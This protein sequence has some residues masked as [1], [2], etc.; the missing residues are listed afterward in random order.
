MNNLHLTNFDVH[1]DFRG[2]LT[3]ILNVSS[4]AVNVIN[5][6]VMHD[7][8]ELLRDVEH[9]ATVTAL[10]F[11]S[12]KESGFLAGADLRVIET[13]QTPEAALEICEAGQGLLQRLESLRVPTVA[14]IN[15]VC[16]GGGLEFAL[17]CRH[18]LVIDDPRTKLGLP[19]VEL[20]LLPGWGGTQRLPRLIGLSA[21]LPMLL[22]GKKVG[23]KEA[24]RIGLADVACK[25]DEADDQVAKLLGMHTSG[26]PVENYAADSSFRIGSALP[27]VFDRSSR[28][29][30]RDGVWKWLKDRTSAGQWLVKKIAHRQIASNS[31]HYPALEAIL[32]AVSVGLSEGVDRGYVVERT[33]FSKLLM[34]ETHRSLLG[35]FFQRERARKAETWVRGLTSK[36]RRI[37]KIGVIGGGV[38]GA[39][40][41]HWASLQGFEI[42]LKEAS[43]ELL[44]A[45][46]SRIKDLL[47]ESIRKQVISPS[48]AALK[49]GAITA[50]TD[51]RAFSDVDLVI[52]AVTERLDIKQ[53]VF[54]DLELFCPGYAIFVSNTS[55]LSIRAIGE[56]IHDSGRVLGLHFFN[57]VHRMQL[58]EVVRT[59]QSRDEHVA[60]LVEFVKKLGKV[61]LVTADS[62]GFVVNRI[63]F[64]YLDEAVRLHCE[65]VPTEQ[66][67]R[68]LKRFGMPMGPL[69]LLDQ[70]GLDVAAHVADSLNGLS[71]DPSPTGGRLH[72]M[73]AEGH[74]G[75]KSGQGFYHYDK[76]GKHQGKAVTLKTTPLQMSSDD[77]RDRIVLRLVNEAA[78]CL[79]EGVV[80]EAWMIDLGM[81]LGTGFAPFLGGP[82]R[83]CE[84]RGEGE[85]VAK[86]EYFQKT[87]GARFAPAQWLVDQI[88]HPAEHQS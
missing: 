4:Q 85:A 40:I 65:G 57:P 52:E 6:S 69:E 48:D 20:G 76:S 68:A 36:P 81:V 71:C 35:L 88:E 83:M 26:G 45:G 58:V 42:V 27:G 10:V 60:M 39:G 11:R 73:V 67:D 18:R 46:L 43:A 50:T 1:R 66:I 84:L 78:K 80:P 79:S 51:W 7:L 13:L 31:E 75:R 22:T 19:E 16:L 29:G 77:I 3:A 61:P 2:V 74:I 41:A 14:V 8:D 86:L 25:P 49:L 82:L 44:D 59:E 12:G 64:P 54:R 24:V 17:A 23:A 70:V 32:N 34:T 56:A 28:P 55:A 62:P 53:A 33:E 87:V 9:D 72:E 5:E 47:D 30:H 15:G 38:M 63:L 37:R 21:S